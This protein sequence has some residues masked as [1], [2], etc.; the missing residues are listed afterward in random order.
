MIFE[1]IEPKRIL[2]VK[3]HGLFIRRQQE[4]ADVYALIIANDVITLNQIGMALTEGPQS[5]RTR[6]MIE[7]SMRPAVDR[8][9]GSAR[10]VVRM[11]GATRKNDTPGKL[12]ATEAK[13]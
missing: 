8:A 13:R 11:A 10:P 2:G 6:Q 3:V 4:V 1:P 7:S 9:V 5:D 12:I